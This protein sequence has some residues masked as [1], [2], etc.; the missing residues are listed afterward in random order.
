M[1]VTVPARL[2]FADGLWE[3][4]PP[5]TGTGPA[6]FNCGGI[7]EPNSIG[8]K[9]LLAAEEAVA[10]E[11]WKAK[12][13]AILKQLRAADRAA[14]HDGDAKDYDGYAGKVYIN[15]SSK[16]RPTT[17]N[18][19]KTPTTRTDGILYSGCNVLLYVDIWAQEPVIKEH[20]RRINCALRG[21]Q[22]VSHNDAFGAGSAADDDE[23]EEIAAPA[24]AASSDDEDLG[25]N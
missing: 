16:I 20:G 8:H 6:K 17:K 23:F 9:R 15:P 7:I 1:K 10:L 13:P 21:V 2:S 5:R 3:A 22:F 14:V 12:G 18:W 11:E 19:D 24:G 4:R 25:V